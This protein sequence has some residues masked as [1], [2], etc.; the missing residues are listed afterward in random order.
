MDILGLVINAVG[1]IF[2]PC[3]AALMTWIGSIS[4]QVSKLELQIAKEY[5]SL[6]NMNEV[7]APIKKDVRNLER[8]MI[9]IADKL[10]VPAISDDQ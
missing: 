8:L 7:M 1:I 2:L 6:S 10:H 9:R 4:K 3:I 5:V